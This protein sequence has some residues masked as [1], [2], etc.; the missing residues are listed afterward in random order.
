MSKTATITGMNT[1]VGGYGKI[2]DVASVTPPSIKHKRLT[3][4]TGAGEKSVATGQVESLDSV[5]KFNALPKAVYEE[6]VKLDKAEIIHKKVI[7]ENGEDVVMTHTCIG[8]FDLEYGEEK[9][10]EY[11]DVTLSQKGLT[12]YVFER[13]SEV[14]IDIDH[15]NNI[16]KIG[17]TDLLEKVRNLIGG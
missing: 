7:K 14:L 9:N 17:G 3:K 12:K 15:D 5:S 16:C 8:A 4:L 2:S 10:G 6:L 1:F 11:L 13:G